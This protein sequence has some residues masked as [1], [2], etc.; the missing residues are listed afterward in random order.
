MM[1]ILHDELVSLIRCC[2]YYSLVI[3]FL[4]KWVFTIE[5]SKRSSYLQLYIGRLDDTQT[6]IKP[7]KKMEYN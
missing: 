1:A 2:C 7:L 6:A 4:Y 5:R 3:P